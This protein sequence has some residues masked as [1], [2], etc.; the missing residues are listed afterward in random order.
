LM[1]RYK[2]NGIWSSSRARY[3]P[4]SGG[5]CRQPL[6]RYRGKSGA[7]PIGVAGALMGDPRLIHPRPHSR[8]PL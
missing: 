2:K 1:L 6:V 5:L 7:R 4:F 3:L 8:I